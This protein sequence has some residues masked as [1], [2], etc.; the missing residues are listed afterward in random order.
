M[1][2]EQLVDEKTRLALLGVI[3]ALGPGDG[4]PNGMRRLDERTY[5]EI[6]AFKVLIR[7]NESQHRGRP[8][9]SV[10]TDKGAVSVDIETGE[11]IAGDAGKWNTP[12]KRAVIQHQKGL[13]D[14]WTKMRPDDQR[15]PP[16]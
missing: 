11:I 8:H 9:C 13:R 3:A 5:P 16:A 1:H 6:K 14:L 10:E 12:I 15:L 2:L 4:L 7:A